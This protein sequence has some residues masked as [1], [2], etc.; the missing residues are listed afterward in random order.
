M[1]KDLDMERRDWTVSDMIRELQ[2]I[3]SPK[4]GEGEA[5]AIIRLIFNSLKGWDNTQLVINYDRPLSEYT[6]SKIQ[7]ILKRLM[8]DEPI[9]YILGKARFYGLDL[10]VT[11]DV[12]IPRP[13]TEE[14]VDLIVKDNPESDLRVLDI[15]TGSGAIAIALARNL[16]FP[17]VTAIDISDAAV[18]VA[19]RNAASLH[20]RI[21]FKVCDIFTYQPGKNE[22]DIIVSNPPYIAEKEKEG[23]DN[24]VLEYEPHS[25]LFVPDDNPLI[26]YSRIAEI[27]LNA[28]S[29][30]GRL[31][32]EINPLYA[33]DLVKMLDN[34]GY[35]DVSLI[36]DISH[37]NRFISA[38]TP[39]AE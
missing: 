28:L 20:A 14:L 4:Y 35:K 36:Q 26:F 30:R 27:G 12:L 21:D 13:E 39:S 33:G 6:L 29:S 5:K 19:K 2:T 15:G 8:R 17:Q 18:K 9:Q 31:Y 7:D 32:L 11:R 10:D 22:Y 3:L 25:A 1:G 16:R 23:M 34:E 38:T 24:N 37:K